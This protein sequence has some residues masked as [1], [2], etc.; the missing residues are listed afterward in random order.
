MRSS[1]RARSI[2]LLVALGAA[3]VLAGAQA[4]AT[5]GAGAK[6]WLGRHA[7][8]EAFMR[9]ARTAGKLEA[10]P[11]GVTGPKKVA[12][13]PGGPVDIIAWKPLGPGLY[14][15]FYESYKSEVAAYEID[16]LLALDMV[17]PKVER[18]IEGETGVAI[19]WVSDTRTFA[20]L[21][22]AAILPPPA[23]A[24]RWN[25]QLVRAMMFDN[26]IG[27]EDPNLGNWLKDD[28]WNLILIDHSRALGTTKSLYHK[29]NHIDRGLWDRMKALDEPILS[30]ALGRWLS[31]GE[32]K[33]ILQRRDRMQQ[34]IDKLVKEK[35]EAGVFLR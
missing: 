31:K 21:G 13:E 34:A 16:K 28:A 35:G 11:V 26:L 1:L 24:E 4:P 17:P 8:I 30:A 20:E 6:T 25:L 27:N 29:M 3:P 18:K 9:S 15:G 23:Q 12:L 32:V 2:L 22:E 10:I 14:R 33:G 19:M 5:S 7:E